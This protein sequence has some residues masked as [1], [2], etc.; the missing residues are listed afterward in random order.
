MKNL[1]LI[2]LGGSLITNK[3]KAYTV[4]RDVI[5][6][7][8]SQI[9]RALDKLPETH[10]I[11]GNG[12]GSFAHYPAKRFKMS[13]GIRKEQQ[14]MGFCIVQDA[15]ARLNRIV[16]GE[17]LKANIRALSI[18][19]SSFIITQKRRIKKIFYE[20]I[21]KLLNLGVTPVVYGDIVADEEYGSCILSTERIFSLLALF[22]KKRGWNI[23]RIIHTGITEGVFDKKGKLINQITKEKFGKMV[24]TF[25]K[26]RGYDVT[27]GMLHK[28]EQ[29]L[30]L[31]EHDIMSLII[32]G[33]S[34]KNLLYRAIVGEEV[35][36]TRIMVRET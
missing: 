20:P 10:L 36:G 28:V 31:A 22:L 13:E 24:D 3:E 5:R 2:K 4:R 33:V 12:A 23:L 25:S 7:L 9:K 1:I 35:A 30:S 34:E 15:A 6:D 14:K 32:N 11:V 16:V 19:P 21:I 17:L 18:N 29:A 8:A 27:G 26:T